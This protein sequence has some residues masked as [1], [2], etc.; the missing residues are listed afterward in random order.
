MR[1][2]L[3]N[4]LDNHTNDFSFLLNGFIFAIILS[5]GLSFWNKTKFPF[6]WRKI[7]GI[8]FIYLSWL[9]F[10]SKTIGLIKTFY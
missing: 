1:E 5:L 3:A 7:W 6:Q 8:F 4:W 2:S 10:L 9:I